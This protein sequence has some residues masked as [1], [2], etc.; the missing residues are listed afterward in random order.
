MN[1]LKFDEADSNWNRTKT[2]KVIGKK[3]NKKNNPRLKY[4]IYTFKG[5]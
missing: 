5:E 3:K 1:D 2:S 4:F